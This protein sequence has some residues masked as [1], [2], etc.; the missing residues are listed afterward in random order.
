MRLLILFTILALAGT[1]CQGAR[2]HIDDRSIIQ[3]EQEM[4][5]F[6]KQRKQALLD[7]SGYR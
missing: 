1:G 6:E 4:V 7:M 5:T 2:Q 3:R